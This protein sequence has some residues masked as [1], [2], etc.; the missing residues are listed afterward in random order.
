MTRKTESHLICLAVLVCVIFSKVASAEIVV[1]VKEG[2]W[3][4]YT[5]T[6]TGNVPEE[7]NV[8][9]ARIEVMHVE[10]KQ[11]D[12]E[13][14]SK[15]SNGTE[16]TGTLTLNLET[17]QIGDCFIIP[18]NLNE[19]DTFPEQT[20]GNITIRG[21]EEKTYLNATRTVV[22]ANTSQTDYYWD[23]STGFLLEATSTYP[24]FTMV[25]KAENTNTWQTQTFGI[26][27]IVPIVLIAA[28]IGAVLAI[29]LVK[30]KK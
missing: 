11:I 4:Q 3:M 18:A 24:D 27:P 12:V 1:G 22:Y 9:G 6:C 2:D 10:G 16:G 28:V 19:Y 14:L 30:T 7:H 21:V 13:I 20:E 5:V 15:Y 23:R 26:D 17:G 25:T 29:V 8:T